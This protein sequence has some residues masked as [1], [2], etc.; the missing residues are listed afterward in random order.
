M[1]IRRTPRDQTSAGPRRTFAG[2]GRTSAGRDHAS[3][4]DAERAAVALLA[5]R[6]YATGELSLKLAAQK[7]E[8][9]A[10]AGALEALKGRHALDDARYAENYVSYHAA[11]GQGPERIRSDLRAFGVLEELIAAALAAGPDWRGLARQQ[12][13]RRFGPEIPAK[14]V[15]KARQ[16]RFLQYRGFSSDHIRS[17]L[18]P[19]F[20]AD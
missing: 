20:D 18:G 15:D 6:D 11:R 8:Q 9:D 4:A 10:I 1:A 13:E 16:A 5:R 17:A 2:P 12:R 3:A 19:D 7:F 14:W